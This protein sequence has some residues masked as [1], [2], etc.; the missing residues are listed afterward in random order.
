MGKPDQ[1]ISQ[2]F[3]IRNQYG[4]K[5][6]AQKLNL[7]NAISADNPKTKKGLQS[8]YDVLLFLIA[9]PDNRSVYE[10]ASQGL[11]QLESYINSS[12]NV[13]AR[14]FNSGVTN[15]KLSAAFSFEIVKWL[16]KRFPKDIT[17]GSFESDDAQ[18]QSI[19]SVVMPKVESEIMQDGNADWR[20]WLKVSARKREDTLGKLITIL[21]QT[22]TR[23]E[24]KDELWGA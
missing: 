6:S 2:L 17:L 16:G 11:R 21:D 12:Q 20:S 10:T 8:W 22:D 13:Q 15:T 24:V 9:Y 19:L 18:L 23:P 4:K 14:L 3:S 7:L 5:F 1:L